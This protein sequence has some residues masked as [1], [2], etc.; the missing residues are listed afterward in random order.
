MMTYSQIVALLSSHMVPKEAGQTQL[1]PML[2][3]FYNET[4]NGN[5]TM[6]AAQDSQFENQF[7]H[8]QEQDDLEGLMERQHMDQNEMEHAMQMNGD[9][10]DYDQEHPDMEGA[11]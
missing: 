5:G 1:V 7:A 10:E 9:M 8:P 2:E 11:H 4:A 3:K 6:I